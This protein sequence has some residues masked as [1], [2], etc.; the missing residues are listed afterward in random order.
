MQMRAHAVEQASLL[1]GRLVFRV[2]RAAKLANPD[3][4]HG[5]RVAIRRFV[6]CLRVFRQFF[7]SNDSKKIRRLLDQIMSLAGEVRNRDIALGLCQEAGLPRTTTLTAPL[8]EGRKE[9][10]QE[11][12]AQLKRLARRDHSLRWRKRLRL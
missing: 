2:N 5:L 8:I 10:A 11:L 7:P 4:I 9:A 6:R 1:L 3:S 12:V